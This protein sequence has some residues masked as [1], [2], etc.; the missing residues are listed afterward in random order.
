M[1]RPEDVLPF[2]GMRSADEALMERIREAIVAMEAAADARVLAVRHAVEHRDG[3]VLLAGSAFHSRALCRILAPCGEV[4]IFCATLGAG[5]D[6]LV[7]AGTATGMSFA[8]LVS[9]AADALL[10]SHLRAWED[11]QR[12]ALAREGLELTRRMCPGYFDWPMEDL[13]RLLPLCGARHMGVAT[14]G[15]HMLTPIKSLAGLLG[16]APAGS[17][18][19]PVDEGCRGCNQPGC[20]YRKE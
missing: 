4:L 18:A 10:H 1:I 16:L 17:G 19:S 5:V 15:A 7:A 14:T 2:L 8:V 12:P 9:A 13:P 20:A 6:R 3:G 11:E